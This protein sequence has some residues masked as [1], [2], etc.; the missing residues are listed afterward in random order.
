MRVGDLVRPIF[1]SNKSRPRIV[2]W[3]DGTWIKLLDP[4]QKGTFLARNYKV[5]N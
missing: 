4:E 2:I 3:T 5:L 1:L